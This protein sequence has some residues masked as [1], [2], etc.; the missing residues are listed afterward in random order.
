MRLIELSA[1]STALS[2]VIII[3]LLLTIPGQAQQN[4]PTIPN[5]T[6]E[7][8][9][10]RDI[11]PRGVDRLLFIDVLT[12]ETA[13]AQVFGERYTPLGNRVLF[14][15]PVNQAVM[16][17]ATDGIVEPHPFIQ[18]END[19]HRV[20]W[21]VSLDERLIAWTLT[22]D[23]PGGLRTLTQI[24]TPGGAERRQI[25]EDGPRPNRLRLLPVAFSVDNQALVMDMHPDGIGRFAPYTQFAGLFRVDFESGAMEALPNEPACFCGAAIRAGQFLRLSLTNDLSGFN[26]NVYNLEFDTEESIP[27][28]RLANFTQAGDILISPDG[29]RAVYALSQIENFGAQNQ[30]IETIFMLVD[31]DNLTQRRL[32][33]PITTYVNPVQW[34]EDNTAILFTSPQL[35]GTWKIGLDDEQ[36]SKVAEAS[37]IGR[38][39]D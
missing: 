5:H 36:L 38:L 29:R 9:V 27:A 11:D 10:E 35:N 33:S 7:V 1:V 12:G 30:S 13:F 34:T 3:I 24:A 37:Y 23:D 15:D 22:F 31:L 32:T 28:M 26:V 8:Y 14:F 6:W 19:A 2:F 4:S 21:L 20:D 17:V 16:T 18:L 25:L 39:G